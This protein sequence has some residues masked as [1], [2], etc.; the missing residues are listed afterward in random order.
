MKT[1]KKTANIA[2]GVALSLLSTTI[3][4]HFYMHRDLDEFLGRPLLSGLM[5]TQ[6]RR[7]WYRW[8]EDG[9]RRIYG[10]VVLICRNASPYILGQQV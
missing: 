5:G 2:V 7:I 3:H 9:V 8:S 1:Y 6:V 10:T 4:R